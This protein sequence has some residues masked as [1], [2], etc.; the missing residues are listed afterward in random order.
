MDE[1][2]YKYSKRDIEE[3]KKTADIRLVIPG[4]KGSGATKYCTCPQCQKTG[5]NKGLQVTFKPGEKKNL[6]K[7]F[8][9]GFTLSDPIAAYMYY[10]QEDFL[11]AV[12][13]VASITGQRL[14]E[15]NP[16]WAKK[17]PETR[18]PDPK[19]RSRKSFCEK[20]LEE[21]GLTIDDVTARWVM[22]DG[23]VVMKPTFAAG[24]VSF[25]KGW[26]VNDTDND[27][28]IH[29]LDLEGK[30]VQY[31]P[32]GSK[33]IRQYI[34]MRWENP[35]AHVSDEGKPIKYQTPWGAPV[36]FYI[37]E[38]IRQKYRKGESIDTIFIQEGEKKAEKATKHGM[39]S[40]GIQGIFNIG[41]AETG[42]I[43][44]LQY[45]V[46]KCNI[47]K[48]VLVMDSD[49]Y[50]LSKEIGAGSTIDSRPRQF[51]KAVIKFKDYVQSLNNVGVM[52]DI[53]WGHV[54]KRDSGE[55][56]IDDLLVGTMKGREEELLP[57]IRHAMNEHDGKGTFLNI[58]KITSMSDYQIRDFWN[59]N[60]KDEFF[61]DHK[62]SIA[63]LP[64]FRF[65]KIFYRRN[66]EGTLLPDGT[67]DG[68]EKIWKA[69]IEENGKKKI[70]IDGMSVLSLMKANGFRRMDTNEDES[71]VFS[72]IR[73]EDNVVRYCSIN[74]IHDFL[75]DY[76]LQ[77]SKDRDI[78]NHF[79]FKLPS[80]IGVGQIARLPSIDRNFDETKP[81]QHSCL[82][83]N[84]QVD[85]TP[86]DIA[87]GA[88]LSLF[89]K[90]KKVDRDFKRVRLFHNI[91][92]EGDHYEFSFT[93]NA[94]ECE[95]LNFLI[96]TSNFTG[97][98]ITE[99]DDEELK[100]LFRHLINKMTA[101]GYLLCEYKYPSDNRAIVAMDGKLS[102]VG[103]SC[104]RT[105]KSLIGVAL[106]MM[107]PVA[108][109]DGRKPGLEGD[110][111]L[112][113]NVNYTTRTVFIDDVRA[114]FDYERLY[115]I[116]TSDMQVNPKGKAR[117]DIPVERSPKFYITTNH[118]ISSTSDSSAARLAIMLFSPYYNKDY[119]PAQKFGH[120]FFSEWDDS[121]WNLFMNLMV[122]CVQLY[123]KAMAEQ[124]QKNKSGVIEA[125]QDSIMRRNLRQ[126]MGE[127][128][129][130]WAEMKFD[131]AGEFVNTRVNRYE[132]FKEFHDLFPGNSISVSAAKFRNKIE[133]FVQ[134]S[135]YHLNIHKYH[136][137]TRQTFSDWKKT[138]AADD[139]S[140]IGDFDKS[141]SKEFFTIATP[142]WAESQPF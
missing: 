66:S 137:K 104:G 95:F 35:A 125:P 2:N 80:Q 83:R 30:P 22:P 97:K 3:L 50:D 31:V 132:I 17:I 111:F 54:N 44:E 70:S 43:K 13:E 29:Y 86:H 74:D 65:G 45:L 88:P 96:D 20:Q 69:E 46:L 55:K 52:A 89:W 14:I 28:I 36:K 117:F 114:K 98:D 116:I 4:L 64:R 130:Q 100:T 115:T 62:D 71:D 77:T 78:H 47:K 92:K 128:F 102:E 15:Q 73:I 41:N 18:E 51:S 91:T 134:Y 124:W 121:Q 87:I 99:L 19:K 68:R 110:D 48:I 81:S 105:G 9:C 123:L 140:F 79:F 32:K 118:A 139:T 61:K 21:S 38:I 127:A 67:L 107:Q 16:K 112:L 108:S 103:L 126:Q 23:S 109:I 59:L 39:L 133:A 8:S 142:Q 27:M 11:K 131:P 129:L 5:R 24:G 63:S 85:I 72:I 94:D 57:D 40:L 113:S 135:G 12:E 138:R 56:G 141:N 26:Q 7:C 58:H 33:K 25:D 120:H 122:D 10:F 6:A 106:K 93:G 136:K 75:F 76:V 84:C 53:Y 90:Y 1:K 60:D 37:P 82:F 34:R 101:I 42:L 119:S 49:W